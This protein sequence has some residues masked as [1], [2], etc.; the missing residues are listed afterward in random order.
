MVKISVENGQK[1][2]VSD[3]L[4]HSTHLSCNERCFLCAAVCL[5]RDPDKPS[6]SVYLSRDSQTWQGGTF[7]LQ[8]IS[9][10]QPGQTFQQYC[11][12]LLTWENVEGVA[13]EGV[14]VMF[15]DPVCWLFYSDGIAEAPGYIPNV[16]FTGEALPE[17][18]YAYLTRSLYKD[19]E[20]VEIKRLHG[21]Y[22]ASTFY[23]KSFDDRGRVLR[24]TVLKIGAR[25]LIAREAERCREYAMPY[26]LN[27]SA[28]VLGT[29]FHCQV[30][31]LRYNFVGIGGEEAELKWLTWYFNNMDVEL[32]KPLFDKIFRK[33]LKPWYGQPL[34][35]KIFPY[36]DHDPTKT[37]FP[38]LFE[39]AELVLGIDSRN[40]SFRVEGR[41]EDFLNPYRFLK[42]EYPK[43]CQESLD[44]Y[45]CVCHGDL[46]MQNILLDNEMNVYLIDFSET[47]PRSVVSDF[48]RLEAI[49]MIES[50]PM[51]TE[52]DFLEVL[53]CVTGFYGGT[54]ALDKKFP[55]TFSGRL[56]KIMQRNM[57]LTL[58][59][60]E[61]AQASSGGDVTF[62]PY[63][64][65]M[66]EWVL[67]IVCYSSASLWQK[68]LSACVAS[69]L[70]E[71][72][73]TK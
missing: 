72:L 56:P 28:M 53:D 36:Q 9:P 15:T 3:I 68:K 8:H 38:D 73:I 69:L 66:L 37:F 22:S 12:S 5:A 57:V 58:K 70:C 2:K 44:Y 18:Y 13:G 65:A 55:E 67:P 20:K 29:A 61:Y 50:Y 49:F 10:M 45:T 62:L 48:A 30:G 27:N 19:S 21:G 60:R 1:I 7:L 32:L 52:R 26:I 33:I 24:P 25:P 4:Q 71:S 23:V 43:R 51:E 34:R 39:K 35:E 64:L 42:E 46:N 16:I 59:M 63:A 31:A 11:R 6:L 14:S 47:R 54:S 40:V 41:T 17:K